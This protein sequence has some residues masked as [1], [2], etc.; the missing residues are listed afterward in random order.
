VD[1]VTVEA[2]AA[3]MRYDWPGN[4][5]ELRNLIENLFVDP[6]PP[7]G[8]DQLP[9]AFRRAGDRAQRP[10]KER[11]VAA[12]C[13]TSWNKSRAAKALHWSRMTLYRKLRK[14]ELHDLPAVPDRPPV[15]L[16]ALRAPVQAS[17]L[18]AASISAASSKPA[19]IANAAS[20]QAEAAPDC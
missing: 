1:D 14:Y 20:V 17:H 11:I 8:I 5:R 9:D 19:L 7:I 16:P 12:L 3:L 13:A 18:A 10:E 15:E 2:M 4:I 6:R